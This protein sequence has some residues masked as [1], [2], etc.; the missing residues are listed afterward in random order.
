[1]KI[2]TYEQG[3]PEWHAARCGIATASGFADVLATVKTGEAASRRRRED[4]FLH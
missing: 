4:S 3:S 1:M 2:S